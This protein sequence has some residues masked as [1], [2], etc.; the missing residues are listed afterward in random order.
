MNLNYK[1]MFLRPELVK[2]VLLHEL[3]HTL[4]P[5]HSPAFW[6][7]L[8]SLLPRCRTLDRQLQDAAVQVPWWAE[9]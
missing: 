7:H 5:D 4:H 6:G 2:Y 1:L 9:Y 3:T 8:R